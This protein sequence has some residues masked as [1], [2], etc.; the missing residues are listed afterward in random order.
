MNLIGPV[1]DG[2][3]LLRFPTAKMATEW[4]HIKH[5]NLKND[6]QIKIDVWS[7]IVGAKGVLQSSWFRVSGILTDQR[8]LRTLA[9]AGGLVGKVI[10]IDE[11]SRYRY[12]YVR[13]RIACRDVSRVPKTAESTLGMYLNE[14]DFEREIP[15]ESGPKVLRSGIKVGE[16]EP[17]PPAKNPRAEL[18]SGSHQS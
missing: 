7:P 3:F 18:T 4:S 13:L 14:F 2:K 5:L 16:H 12:D 6:A 9:K 17:Q 10:E 8:S 1:G 11:C 15:D